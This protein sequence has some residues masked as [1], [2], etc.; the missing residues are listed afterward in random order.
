MYLAVLREG[1]GPKVVWAVPPEGFGLKVVWAV[2]PEGFGPN[3]T[4]KI[5]KLSNLRISQKLVIKFFSKLRY[6]S[7]ES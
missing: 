3:Y 7:L 5:I 4:P 6:S 1:F 2:P